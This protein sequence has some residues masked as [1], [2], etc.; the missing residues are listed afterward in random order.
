MVQHNNRFK[1][2]RINT[3]SFWQVDSEMKFFVKE[4]ARQNDGVCTLLR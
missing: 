2:C 3:I 1:K 4:L